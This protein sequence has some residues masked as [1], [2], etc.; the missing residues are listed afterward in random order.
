MSRVLLD[1]SHIEPAVLGGAL[2]GGGGG[3]WITD[4]TDWGTLAVSLGAPALI[5]VDELPGDALLVTAAG[6]GAPASPGRF[7]RP[8]D[9]LRAL[10]LV[11]EAAHAPIAGIIANENGAAATVNGWLQ[12]AV[13]GIPVVDAPC[14]GRAHPS[15]LLG[16]MGLHR[17]PGSG[18][19]AP[20]R[21]PCRPRGRPARRRP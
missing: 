19:S 20:P 10:E 7:A 13:F 17:R 14:N 11:M 2:L 21:S 12:A 3:G 4:G 5:T 8:V 18:G 15:G 1:R 9:F 6:V 16:A